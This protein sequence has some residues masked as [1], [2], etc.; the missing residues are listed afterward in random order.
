MDKEDHYMSEMGND[1][2]FGKGEG[3][4]HLGAEG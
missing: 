3:S 1:T 2:L 4:A